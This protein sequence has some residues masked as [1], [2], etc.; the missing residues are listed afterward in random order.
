MPFHVYKE[1]DQELRRSGNVSLGGKHGPFAK[2]ARHLLENG[3]EPP[4]E[5]HLTGSDIL[6]YHGVEKPDQHQLIVE[7][8]PNAE[9]NVSLY[10]ITDVWG[11]TK[12]SWTPLALRLKTIFV[13]RHEPDPKSFQEQFRIPDDEGELVHEFLYL[14]GGAD[15]ESWGWGRSGTVNAVL[16]WPETFQ[17]FIGEMT[18][19]L[20]RVE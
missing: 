13:D 15:S 8:K 11:H 9:N 2:Y 3:A 10:Q 6:E 7:L 16:L 18:K 12:S 19:D 17:Y 1:S 20:D 14:T 4:I 5:W